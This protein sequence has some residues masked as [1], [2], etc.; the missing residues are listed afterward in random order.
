[1]GR[2]YFTSI[3]SILVSSSNSRAYAK[4]CPDA[5]TD[6]VQLNCFSRKKTWNCMFATVVTHS[7]DIE[8]RCKKSAINLYFTHR[9]CL[10]NFCQHTEESLL[11]RK[12]SSYQLRQKKQVDAAKLDIAEPGSELDH[13]GRAPAEAERGAAAWQPADP[14]AL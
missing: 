11:A 2:N 7:C 6:S 13:C 8:A 14:A 1:M 3:T 5:R 9:K 12:Q 10:P 4:A